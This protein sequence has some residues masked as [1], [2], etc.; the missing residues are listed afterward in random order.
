M[1]GDRL[2]D[3]RR[4]LDASRRDELRDE[5]RAVHDL[6]L[7][8]EVAV[9]VLEAVEA[10]RAVRDDL[11][12]LVAV[13]RLDVLL[14]E[15]LEEVLVAHAPRRVAGAGLLGAEDR[16]GDAGLVQDL[17]EGLATRA[18]RG[19]RRSRRSRPRRGP[20]CRGSSASAIVIDRQVLR[21]VARARRRRCST[22]CRWS[23]CRGRRSAPPSG[24]SALSRTR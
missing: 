8:A 2:R 18:W 13:E 24:N 10:V 20:R 1:E 11:L 19:P 9:L 3:R 12:D 6:V 22:G 15:H 23:P 21:P 7:A 5:L 4:Q 16:E 14:R 17:D